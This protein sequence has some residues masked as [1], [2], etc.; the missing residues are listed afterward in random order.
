MRLITL[1]TIAVLALG[2]LWPRDAFAQ[3]RVQNQ[4][5]QRDGQPTVRYAISIPA[6][7]S[8]SVKVPLVLAL[9]FGGD[10]AGA[11][12]AV[13]DILIGPGLAELGAIIVAPDSLNGGWDSAENDRAVI[14][15]LDTVLANYSI[16]T[17]KILVTG[18]SMGGA[19]TWHFGSKYPQRFSAAIPLAGRPTPAAAGWKLPILAIHSRIDEVAPFAPTEARIAELKKAGVRAELIAVNGISHYQT[20][21]FADP[22]RQ[23]V[24]W[25]REVWKK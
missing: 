25:L 5:L 7:Y 13:L 21:R 4:T 2:G 17:A 14:Q 6:N 9:H 12:R 20:F 16:D 18:F 22:L 24:P 11:G 19:G 8:P 1:A 3:A 10:P 15:L 23:A